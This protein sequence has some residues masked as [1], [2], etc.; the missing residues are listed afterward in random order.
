MIQTQHSQWFLSFARPHHI[1]VLLILQKQ[2]IPR[3][4]LPSSF[5]LLFLLSSKLL[6]KPPCSSQFLRR[7]FCHLHFLPLLWGLVL[8]S[9]ALWYCSQY[10]HLSTS[11]MLPQLL[12]IFLIPCRAALPVPF[13]FNSTY[14]SQRDLFKTLHIMAWSR[15][16]IVA[17]QNIE[18][19][20]QTPWAGIQKFPGKGANLYSQHYLLW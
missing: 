16:N 9:Q 12:P 19:K 18:N 10:S 2:H 1:C 14:C 5:N 6:L 3:R 4:L 15:W 7:K 11:V 20:I 17:P 8:P 13:L